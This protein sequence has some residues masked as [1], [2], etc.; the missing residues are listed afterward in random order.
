M[1]PNRYPNSTSNPP[2]FLPSTHK[3][4]TV[5]PWIAPQEESTKTKPLPWTTQKSNLGKTLVAIGGGRMDMGETTPIDEKIVQ[6]AKGKNVLFIPT[7]STDSLAEC[8]IFQKQYGENLGCNVQNLLLTA[9]PAPSPTAI[10]NM[11]SKADIIYVGDGNPAFLIS[12]WKQY[13][14]APLLKKAYQKGTIL[15]GLGAGATCWF[16][17]AITETL[18]PDDDLPKP[19]Q[20]QMPPQTEPQYLDLDPRD[21]QALIERTSP[22][23]KTLGKIPVFPNN[24]DK[25]TM[26][27]PPLE[28]SNE[29]FQATLGLGFISGSA[30]AHYRNEHPLRRAFL[31]RMKA[32]PGTG[33]CIDDNA[34][35]VFHN[36]RVQEVLKSNPKASVFRFVSRRATVTMIS[37]NDPPP[38]PQQQTS[39]GPVVNPFSPA[40]NDHTNGPGAG[41]S[42]SR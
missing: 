10:E 17:K 24:D 23:K 9:F 4:M 3:K 33:F 18:L 12:T 1:T 32:M 7:A 13:G 38:P 5:L 37:L 34:A 2:S 27:G 15:A 30:C 20:S 14:L 35:I 28:Q 16:D 26:T 31:F 25:Y 42:P 11:I 36:G 40:P 29:D 21:A 8:R 22:F 41:N 39:Q 6:M 19:S